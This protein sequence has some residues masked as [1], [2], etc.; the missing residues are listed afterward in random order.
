MLIER[1]DHLRLQEAPAELCDD[2]EP[3]ETDDRAGRRNLDAGINEV[4]G[5]RI[6]TCR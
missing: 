4:S 3:E 5:E 1:L 6:P 2:V